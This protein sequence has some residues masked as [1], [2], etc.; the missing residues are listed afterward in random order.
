MKQLKTID[1]L[2]TYHPCCA[3]GWRLKQDVVVIV[4]PLSMAGGVYNNV[5]WWSG[6]LAARRCPLQHVGSFYSFN[7]SC[8]AWFLPW[9]M[10]RICRLIFWEDQPGRKL[11][12]TPMAVVWSSSTRWRVFV[13]VFMLCSEVYN[14]IH[15]T[16]RDLQDKFF[17]IV[18]MLRLEVY[19]M[20]DDCTSLANTWR[21]WMS[22]QLESCCAPFWNIWW[23]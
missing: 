18:A 10:L 2:E 4:S 14:M 15:V 21:F 20:A 6:S 8:M 7:V 22:F 5:W 23:V 11:L 1:I 17:T 9:I 3:D 12:D 19:N 16:L 13:I